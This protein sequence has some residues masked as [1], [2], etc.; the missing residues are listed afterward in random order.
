M[1]TQSEN[2]H[3]VQA[4]GLDIYY[5]EY[6]QGEP[7]ILIHGGILTAE[8][9]G[10]YIAGLAE[11]YRVITAD[12]RGHGR[13]KN[14]GG[15]LSFS[16]LAADVV[17]FIQALGL[18]KPLVFGYSDGGQTALEIGMHYPGVARAFVVGGAHF[19]LTAG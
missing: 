12:T 16:L 11:H 2:G 19:E 3:Y 6:G 1:M 5:Q 10:P 9:W 7:L 8:S 14:S 13:T 17:A 18:E 4:N 15:K